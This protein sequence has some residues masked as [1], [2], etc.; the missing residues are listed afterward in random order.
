MH[1]IYTYKG[2]KACLG[3]PSNLTNEGGDFPLSGAFVHGHFV[4]HL[5]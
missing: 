3:F 2:D 4:G 1:F 5:Q